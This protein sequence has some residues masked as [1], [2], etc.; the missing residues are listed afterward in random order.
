LNGFAVLVERVIAKELY[1]EKYQHLKKE[2]KHTPSDPTYKR[3]LVKE[4]RNGKRKT[5]ARQSVATT[6]IT[7]TTK[8]N[9]LTTTE[10]GEQESME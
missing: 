1:K 8:R 9:T 4:V 5:H 2:Q 7:F 6:L 3:R 10:Q